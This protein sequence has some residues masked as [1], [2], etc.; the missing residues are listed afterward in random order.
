MKI[1]TKD[2]LKHEKLDYA[3]EIKKGAVF[4]YPTDTIYGIGCNARL[5]E[6]VIRLRA[7]KKQRDRP[8]S[9]IVP[10]KEW[11]RDNCDSPNRVEMRRWI[12]KLPGSYTIILKLKK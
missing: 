4:I 12:K 11:I 8:L 9:V 10:S 6:A 7:I 3:K 2:E 1:I 5:P